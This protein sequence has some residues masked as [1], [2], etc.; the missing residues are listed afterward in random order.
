M[1]F[2]QMMELKAAGVPISSADLLEAASIQNKSRIIEN[3]TKQ[4]QAQAQVQQQQTDMQMQL[5][6]SQIE[7]AHAR[8]AADMGLYNERTSRI[9]ENRALAIQK[10][11]EANAEDERAMLDKVKALK[12]LETIDL[13]HLQRLLA[14]AQ[15]LKSQEV[16]ESEEKSHQ[17]VASSAQ[18]G[19]Q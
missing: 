9:D 4:E 15:M 7:L 6:Q 14:M 5:Q 19:V 10:I 18:I 12:E 13:D 11:H 16:Q 17:E 2:A 8:A 1:Q 3:L